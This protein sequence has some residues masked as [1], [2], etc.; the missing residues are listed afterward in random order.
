ME[1]TTS[2]AF[3]TDNQPS[4]KNNELKN[5]DNIEDC[6]QPHQ[7]HQRTT[8]NG[9]WC[10][11]SVRSRSSTSFL[12]HN[13]LISCSGD[14]NEVQTTISPPSH[15]IV[16]QDND[17]ED[18]S[19]NSSSSESKSR[20]CSP[21]EIQLSSPVM[22]VKEEKED[23]VNG[24]YNAEHYR[25]KRRKCT[26]PF[27]RRT[28][29]KTESS[30]TNASGDSD[31]EKRESKKIN[32]NLKFYKSFYVHVIN[33]GIFYFINSKTINNFKYKVIIIWVL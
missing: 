3:T 1:N 19:N 29:K 22:E 6:Q 30:S 16:E 9:R 25:I 31:I 17:N 2:T 32:N 24:I 20:S 21:Q 11:S 23:D 8:G 15:P 26:I 33:T 12:I 5:G 7:R 18:T 10:T 4:N 13:L 27:R 28:S 14:A